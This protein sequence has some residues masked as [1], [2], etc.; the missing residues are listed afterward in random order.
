MDKLQEIAFA[1]MPPE[2]QQAALEAQE[3]GKGS[4]LSGEI[5]SMM[6]DL[7]ALMGI[8]NGS[9]AMAK[10]M[11]EASSQVDITGYNYA[12]V[13]YG[14]DKEMYPNRIIVGSETYPKDLD[15]NWDLVEK[16]PNVIG[17]FDWTAWDYLGEAGIGKINYGELGGG[18]SFYA[19]YPCKA[20]YCGDINLIGDRRPV[21][22][23]RE[24][25]WGLRKAPYIAVQPPKY[26]GVE[27]K[28]TD[29]SMTDAVRS[30]NWAGYENKPVVVEVYTDAEEAE[31]LVNGK[32]IERRKVGETKKDQVIFDT[33]Y[34]PGKIEVVV[35]KDGK[36]TGRD[37]IV[38]AAD[39]VKI[40][41]VADVE[42][43]PVDGSDVGY[44][45][46]RLVDADGNFNPDVVKAVSVEIDGP[47]VILGY[48]SAD[49]D[50]EENYF[51]KV[52]RTFEGR[53]RAAVRAT[54]DAG[55]IKVTFKADGCDDVTVVVPVK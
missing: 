45:E 3:K 28:M 6:T 12:A 53:L 33:I 20:A 1:A 31:L 2:M 5:N 27:K 24:I 48:G 29:W 8:I 25:I 32:T 41:A 10:I 22:Y 4:E 36:E 16:M 35:Y 43:V 14:T 15:V 40:T 46:V 49:P 34:V 52:A 30:W 55:E 18:M 47:G 13:R 19:P 17:D 50:S 37:E 54:G 21:S 9:P 7:G 38:T 51:D 11:E 44:I 39:D 23:W 42:S 26:Y